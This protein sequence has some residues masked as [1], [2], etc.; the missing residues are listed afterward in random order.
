[1]NKQTQAIGHDM[2]RLAHDASALLA[3]TADVAGEKVGEARKRLACVLDRGRDFYGAVR[4]K[5]YEG[6][7]AADVAVHENLYQT[8]AIGI[9]AG[10]LLGYLFARRGTCHRG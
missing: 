5:A 6:S 8:I 7:R 1:M 3:A 9:G 4:E 10:A 2:E